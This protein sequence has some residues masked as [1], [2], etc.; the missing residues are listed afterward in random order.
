MS[1]LTRETIV[2]AVINGAISVCFFL[3]VFG[4]ADTVLVRGLGN[5]AFDFLQ[6]SFAIGLMAALVPALFARRALA[7]GRISGTTPS[8]ASVLRGAMMKG[9]LALLLGAAGAGAAL[10]ISNVE[11][12]GWAAA[13]TT[14]VLYGSAL[15]GLVTA[16]TL[17]QMLR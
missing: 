12:I 17:R 8:V 9:L 2:S 1:Y 11:V 4:V 13:L 16:L 14:K 6:Q 3:A 15:G 10:L 7:L 5:F